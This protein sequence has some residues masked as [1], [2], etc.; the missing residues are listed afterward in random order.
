MQ[1]MMLIAGSQIYEN[2]EHD[3]SL[4]TVLESFSLPQLYDI[5]Q[6][7]MMDHPSND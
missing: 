1:L 4:C 7:A 6:P 3:F 2:E 5:S